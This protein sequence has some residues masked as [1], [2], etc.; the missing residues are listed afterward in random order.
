[1][2]AFIKVPAAGRLTNNFLGGRT[3]SFL[4]NLDLATGELGELV[5]IVR[6]SHRYVV[7]RTAV[8][9]ATGR[10]LRGRT[11]PG[12]REA[13][14]LATR[15][16]RLH[17]R[18]ATIGWDLSPG[19]AGWRVLEANT[20]WGPGGAQA[21]SGRGLRPQLARLFPEHWR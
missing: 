1:M 2:A 4:S 5:G 12:W 17:P 13:I 21:A 20:S 14:E 15:G 10:R 7:E 8:H 18:T 19:P 9:P 16:A 11:L 6:P 3:G